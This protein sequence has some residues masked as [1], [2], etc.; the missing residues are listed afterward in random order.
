LGLLVY[1]HPLIL[2]KIKK[3]R[4]I[5]IFNTVF[6]YG[7][8]VIATTIMPL[9]VSDPTKRTI[10]FAVFLLLGNITNALFGSVLL[11]GI[12]TENITNDLQETLQHMSS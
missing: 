3:R 2:S 5:L 7:M 1:F 9:F 4:A 11:L 8:V 6:Y 10:W 12:Y